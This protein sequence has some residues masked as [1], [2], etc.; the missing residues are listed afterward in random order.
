MGEIL[1]VVVLTVLIL[2]LIISANGQIYDKR[3]KLK[4]G[5]DDCQFSVNS[6]YYTIGPGD[7]IKI[8]ENCTIVF[9]K[10][11]QATIK[12]Y[13]NINGSIISKTS[14]ITVTGDVSGNITSNTGDIIINGTVK[15]T[16][17][18]SGYIIVN[19]QNIK[20]S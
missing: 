12:I 6:T 17:T 8:G 3:G 13:G 15:D 10:N 5:S 16:I 18:N 4:L 14:D 9:H 1:F 2:I 19:E 11:T 20:E 7:E